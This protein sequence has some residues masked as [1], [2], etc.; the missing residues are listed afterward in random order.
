M[1]I[2]FGIAFCGIV[3]NLII[4]E[5][6]FHM[7]TNTFGDCFRVVDTFPVVA[8]TWLLRA[9]CRWHH[10]LENECVNEIYI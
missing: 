3:S 10:R 1:K 4:S 9:E 8:M 2:V 6:Y 5:N 7:R